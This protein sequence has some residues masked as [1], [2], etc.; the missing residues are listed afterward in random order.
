M[1][2]DL[3]HQAGY[4]KMNFQQGVLTPQ[5]FHRQCVLMSLMHLYLVSLTSAVQIPCHPP[6]K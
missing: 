6:L 2:V 3:R 1:F 5:D 4:S